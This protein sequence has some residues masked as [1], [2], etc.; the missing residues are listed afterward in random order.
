MDNSSFVHLH[1]HSTRSWL[2][3]F[4]TSAN[5]IKRAAELGFKSIALTDHGNVDGAIEWQQECKKANIL[6][7]VGCEL[8]VVSDMNKKDKGEKRSHLTVLVE[9]IN[10]WRTLCKWLTKASLEGFYHRPRCDYE[11]ILNSNLDGLIFLTGCAASVINA[12]DRF[13]RDLDEKANKDSVF[14]E[15]MP[16]NIKSQ[17]QLHAKIKKDYSEWPLVATNDN[18]YIL[19]EDWEAQEVLLAIQ[20][21]AKWNDPNRWR[22]G[23]K[24][25]HL[26]TADE[27]LQ[28]FEKQGDFTKREVY[29]AIERTVQIAERCSNFEIKKQNISLP[30]LPYK[31]SEQSEFQE[32]KS[33]C[34]I[35]LREFGLDRK[36]EYK[37]R[38]ET[39]LALIGKKDF[40]R[41]FLIVQDFVL[42]CKSKGWGVGP[43][44]GSVAGA[45]IAHLLHITEGLDPIKYDLPFSRFL[46]EDRNDLPDI[47][48]DIEKRYRQQAVDALFE[49]YGK[50]NV[51]YISTE[52]QMKSKAVIRDIGR[53]FDLPNDEVSDMANS[54]WDNPDHEGSAIEYAVERNSEAKQFAEKHPKQIKL[55][56]K[57]EGQ[58]RNAGRHAAGV[59]ISGEDLTQGTRCVL[60]KRGDYQVVNWNMK[61]CEHQGLMKL[62]VLGLATIS[63]LEECRT[64]IKQSNSSFEIETIPEEDPEAFE[65]IDSGKTAGL[66]Q[67]SARPLT[68]LCTQMG[69]S[70]FEHLNAALALIRPGPSESGMTEE[71]V[72]RKKGK[73]WDK[74]HPI[75]EDITKD[76]YGQLVY[77]EQVMKVIS[78][79]AG[80]SES[81]ADSIRR[82]IGKKRDPKEFE[83]YKKQF[84]DGCAKQKTFSPKE[85]GEFW[86]GLLHWA[87]YGFG[88][89]HSTAYALIAY[90][91]AYL[92]AHYPVEFF[93]ATLSYGEYDEKK[94]DVQKHKQHIID[95]AKEIGL[96]I[97]P[98]KIGISDA[99]RW[100]IKDNCLYT[101]F[102]E[103]KSFGESNALKCVE[104]K[105]VAKPKNKGFFNI[106]PVAKKKTKIEETLE[107]IDAYDPESIPSNLSEYL[108]FE[109]GRGSNKLIQKQ[110]RIL[111]AEKI[112]YRSER[113]SKCKRCS[114]AEE[115]QEPILT[116]IGKYNIFVIGEAPGRREDIGVQMRDGSIKRM[117]F[118][119]PAG[120]LLWSTLAKYN[121]NRSD[122]Y[123]SNACR[124]YPSKTKT[125]KEDHIQACLP[126]LMD[127]LKKTKCKLVLACGNI[128][129]KAFTGK[130]GG[131]TT[132]A[133]QR[134]W[135]KSLEAYVVWSLHPS[136][137]LRNPR[138]RELFEKGIE[139]FSKAFKE[140]TK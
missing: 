80:M 86:D 65:F 87:R 41:Y 10:G 104:N 91:T 106:N 81:D 60:V 18:H 95:E 40:S 8:Y 30:N 62:D 42:Y 137:V 52:M 53:V 21:N 63:V 111:K 102:A 118:I 55:A 79:M 136:A 133:G 107:K 50:N 5:Y 44:R 103:I 120:D 82:V 122:V 2:D 96:S 33:R 90:R 56:L 113:I 23:F 54:I 37:E 38:L 72:E 121:I 115:A 46:S 126:W 47:D 12:S 76:T 134:Q 114:L 45:L 140:A 94:K 116:S 89:G 128:C 97:M 16:H 73:H 130:D 27:M 64:L 71:Y 26:R 59:I 88:R 69:I 57:L 39:E 132:L 11:Q 19:E 3:G 138:N 32:L 17:K 92:K 123:V 51:A 31:I 117:G 125:P 66:F 139:E 127:E 124:C 43:G 67:V 22:F 49:I 98:P 25:L 35:G 4:G 20:S 68:E 74:D 100:T 93:C 131:I 105:I 101:P 110:D 99:L 85:A 78:R 29:K 58:F 61:N 70:C 15:V 119:G 77:Q 129:L 108:P 83:P 36:T 75:Y 135:I 6:P 84:V 7:V 112:K 109:C 24:G 48:L 13:V 34:L 28:A 14:I 9:N 1:L